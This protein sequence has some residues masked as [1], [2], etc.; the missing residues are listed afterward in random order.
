M[1]KKR[2]A[3]VNQRYGLEVN[4]GSEYYTRLIAERLTKDYEVEVLTSTALSYETWKNYYTRK[5]ERIN[6]VTV[7][8]FHVRRERGKFSMRLLGKLISGPFRLNRKRICDLWVRQQGPQVPG[9]VEYIRKN[10]EAYAAI[11]FVTYLYYPT[12]FG[13]PEAK[14][15]AIFIP[16]AHDEPYIHFQS[17]AQL[18]S[19]PKAIIYLTDEEKKLV[20]SLY[21]NDSIPS[22]VAGVGVDVP[23]NVDQDA[24]RKKYD[25]QGDYLIY[26]GRVDVSKGCDE[27]FSFFEQFWK[28]EDTELTLV[29]MGQ[30]FMDVPEEPHV[31]YLGFVSEEDKFNGVAGAKALWLPSPFESLSISV[32]EAMSLGI[33][34]LVNGKCEVL[35]GHCEKSGGGFDYTDYESFRKALSLLLKDP[36][37]QEQMG[38]NAG[39]YIQKHYLWN[40]ILMGIK[41]L[42]EGIEC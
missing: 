28:E 18:F 38:H 30:K 34:V 27:M 14:D 5:K 9:L 41:Q 12:V 11:I 4:G 21:H 25:I 2:I 22:I 19:M 1:A 3:F 36:E 10:K 31:K 32:L 35:R 42:I 29:V 17:H 26:T 8:R 7:R 24:F 13:M 40:E 20:N 33:P 37:L 6:G 16:T 23:E 39:E 15:R